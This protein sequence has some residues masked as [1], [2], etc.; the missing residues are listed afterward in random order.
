MYV[1]NTATN[2]IE[3]ADNFYY[4]LCNIF[5]ISELKLNMGSMCHREQ[6]K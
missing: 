3:N 1:E 5:S 2:K 6:R 4:Y